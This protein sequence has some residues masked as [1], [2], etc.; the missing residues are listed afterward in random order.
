[1]RILPDFLKNGGS[2]RGGWRQSLMFPAV[3]TCIVIVLGVLTGTAIV[4]VPTVAWALFGVV[5]ALALL[6]APA[7]IRIASAILAAVCSRLVVATGIFSSIINFFHF[8]LALG[9]AMVSAFETSH[10]SPVRRPLE[11][12]LLGL[13]GL[14]VL[15]WII[16]GGE[17]LRPLLDWL[18]FCEPFLIVY[19]IVNMPSD[20]RGVVVLRGLAMAIFFGQLPLMYFQAFTLG[21]SDPVRGFFIDMGAGAHVA[22]AVC[23]TGALVCCSRVLAADRMGTR[24]LWLL[25]GAALFFATILADAKQVIIPFLPALVLV[26]IVSMRFRLGR[27]LAFLP[28]LTVGILGAFSLYRPL[29]IALD[30]TL[31]SRGILGKV[32]AFAVIAEKLSLSWTRWIVGLGPGNSISRVALMGLEAFVKRDSPVALLNLGPAAVTRELWAMT[33]SNWLYSASSVWTGISSWLGLFGDLGL[34]GLGLFGWTY[35]RVWWNVRARHGWGAGAARAVL[36]MM[37][38]LGLLYSWLEEPGFTLTAALVMGL[39]FTIDDGKIPDTVD[40]PMMR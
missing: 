36:L 35:G 30:W 14:S 28:L 32:E 15:S 21:L 9:A 20:R 13:L 22:G 26:L 6:Q 12:G 34:A 37:A 25:G 2:L 27:V 11:I 3:T 1:V 19:A 24:L 39:G 16:N 18:V 10:R 29:Q 4:T 17:V 23:L 7:H 5:M 38:L 31:I 40:R 33:T 8:P